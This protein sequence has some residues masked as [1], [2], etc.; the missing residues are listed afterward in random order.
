MSTK[1]KNLLNIFTVM[2]F[3]PPACDTFASPPRGPCPTSA[4]YPWSGD[5]M[6]CGNELTEMQLVAYSRHPSLWPEPHQAGNIKA[7]FVRIGV[8]LRAPETLPKM[9]SSPQSSG[10]NRLYT[11]SLT[12]WVVSWNIFYFP[13]CRKFE[14]PWSICLS[15]FIK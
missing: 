5:F 2:I 14:N 6:S 3:F 12:G 11:N 4:P 13:G 8:N 15:T 9:N 7:R 10:N 1:K